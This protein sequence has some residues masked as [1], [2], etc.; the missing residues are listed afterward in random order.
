MPDLVSWQIK[1]AASSKLWQQLMQQKPLKHMLLVCCIYAHDICHVLC[2]ATSGA[3]AHA[4]IIR[5]IFVHFHHHTSTPPPPLS[6]T[7]FSTVT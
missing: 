5:A 3:T 4:T 6:Y 2:T 7:A 1:L